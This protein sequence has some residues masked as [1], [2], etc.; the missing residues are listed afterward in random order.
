MRGKKTDIQ[1][2]KRIIKETYEE[3]CQQIKNR[4]KFDPYEKFWWY[5]NWRN[6]QFEINLWLIQECNKKIWNWLSKNE[7]ESDE[8]KKMIYEIRRSTKEQTEQLYDSNVR[9][10]NPKL[11]FKILKR[12]KFTCQYCWAKWWNSILQIDHVIPW[13]KWWKTTEDNLVTSCFECNIWK[14]NILLWE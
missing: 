7:I 9:F 3:N 6:T 1:T 5:E 13:S 11:R 10:I 8:D 4:G 12:D 2:K 14:S